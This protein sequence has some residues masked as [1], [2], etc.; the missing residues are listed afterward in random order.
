MYETY[1]QS[2]VYSCHLQYT[3]L[4]VFEPLFLPLHENKLHRVHK[5]NAN[6]KK[7]HLKS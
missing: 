6:N 4:L 5:L 2:W 1:I 7:K 3:F